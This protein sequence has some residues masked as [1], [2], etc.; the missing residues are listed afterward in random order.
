MTSEWELTLQK[1]ENN[2]A[3]AGIFQKEMEN[4]ASSITNELLETSIAENN[5]PKCDLPEM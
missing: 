2:E 4:Y 5:L 3:D 1:I